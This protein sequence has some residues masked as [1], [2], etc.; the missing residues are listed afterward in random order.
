VEIWSS[1]RRQEVMK[2]LN[3]SKHCGFHCIRNESNLQLFE[4]ADGVETP[5]VADYDRFI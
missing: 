3:P 4:L 1:S 2:N 5:T